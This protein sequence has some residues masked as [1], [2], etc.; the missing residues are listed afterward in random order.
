MK[1]NNGIKKWGKSGDK[2]CITKIAFRGSRVHKVA[3]LKLVSSVVIDML[4]TGLH[5]SLYITCKNIK[6]VKWLW[7]ERHC[8]FTFFFFF[9]FCKCLYYGD[10]MAIRTVLST[11]YWHQ[12]QARDS[13]ACIIGES[14]DADD[15]IF[16]TRTFTDN[17]TLIYPDFPKIFPLKLCNFS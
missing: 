15:T 4:C 2:K 12:Y 16:F 9:W 11:Q 7:R 3:P 17:I 8:F 13:A 14:D 6:V 5:I 1:N 10:F